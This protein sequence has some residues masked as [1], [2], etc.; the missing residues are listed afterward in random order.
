MTSSERITITAAI[1]CTGHCMSKSSY[2]PSIE[3]LP[4]VLD[5]QHSVLLTLQN[6][7]VI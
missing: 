1:L 6:V 2:S 5:A 4:I 3:V 7:S